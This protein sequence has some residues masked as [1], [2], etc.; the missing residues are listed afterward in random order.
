MTKPVPIDW[1]ENLTGE[2]LLLQLLSRISYRYPDENERTW[3]QSLIDED[4]FSEIPL[5]GRQEETKIGLKFI[6]KWTECG[7]TDE[8][9]ERIQS[10]YMRLFIGP[11][12]VLAPPWESVYFNEERLMFQKQTLDVRNWYR[13]FGLES[14]KIRQE[15]DDHIGLE[16]IFLSNLA[17][18]AIQ[19]LTAQDEHRFEELMDAQREFIRKHLGIWVLT[20]C[21]LVER[22]AQTNFYKG[23]SHLIH[24][25]MNEL[26][27]LLKVPLREDA[28]R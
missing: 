13:K 23:L 16:L 11:A 19:S 20:W 2:L 15:P 27:E 24:G 21:G 25:A 17:S 4:V 12:E 6:D 7:L 5:A 22:N 14:E 28:T 8:N 1:Q 9:F 18:L 3:L 26:S 10:D